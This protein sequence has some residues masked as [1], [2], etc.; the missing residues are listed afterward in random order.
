GP[1]IVGAMGYG[2]VK[3]LT[4]IGD[5]VNVASRLETIAKELD[6]TLVVSEPTILLAG[7]DTAHLESR[8][9]TVRG[10]AEPLRVY[11]IPQEMSTRFA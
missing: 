7:S 10:R 11:T 1:A 5:T 9:I 8:E 6:V 2:N 4:A 3:N